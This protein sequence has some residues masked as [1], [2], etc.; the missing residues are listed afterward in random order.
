MGYVNLPEG[1]EP[2]PSLSSCLVPSLIASSPLPTDKKL[3]VTSLK[4]LKVGHM[5]R[6]IAIRISMVGPHH[7]RMSDLAG[8]A[9][10]G[11]SQLIHTSS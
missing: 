10:A 11:G 8:Q 6:Y 9:R 2:K 1:T 5:S 7:L 3:P 4:K